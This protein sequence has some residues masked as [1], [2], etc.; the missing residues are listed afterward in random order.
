MIAEPTN[1][2]M[3]IS[4]VLRFLRRRLRSAMVPMILWRGSSSRRRD[5]WMTMAA[6]SPRNKAVARQ[7]LVMPSGESSM[8]LRT[9][10]YTSAIDSNETAQTATLRTAESNFGSTAI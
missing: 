10:W 4:A 3:T 5:E 7:L 1:R 8:A 2:P 9:R 6:T